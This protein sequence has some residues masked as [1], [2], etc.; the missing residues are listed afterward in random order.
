MRKI[1]EIKNTE[2]DKSNLDDITFKPHRF[3][4]FILGNY[5]AGFGTGIILINALIGIIVAVLGTFVLL[6]FFSKREEN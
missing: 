1:E 4:M 5:I 3:G 2:L 6:Y